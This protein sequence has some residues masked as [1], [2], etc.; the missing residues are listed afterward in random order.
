MTKYRLMKSETMYGCTAKA[1]IAEADTEQEIQD[2]F[3]EACSDPNPYADY[4]AE[5]WS[6]EYG[7]HW[8]TTTLP[9]EYEAWSNSLEDD[10]ILPF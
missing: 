2:L 1:C 5:E 8:L 6:D 4:W 3:I 9:C 10:D 7:G